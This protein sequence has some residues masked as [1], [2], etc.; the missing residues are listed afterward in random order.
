V[1]AAYLFVSLDVS[2][3]LRIKNMYHVGRFFW[4]SGVLVLALLSILFLTYRKQG[5]LFIL[6]GIALT[7]LVI[8]PLGSNR[9]LLN[10]NFGMWLAL[11]LA[12][13][14]F[15]NSKG[16]RV[17]A[18]SLDP[19]SL[20]LFK[21]LVLSMV[22]LYAL[23]AN[24][25]ETYRDS[26]DRSAL[27]HPVHHRYFTGLFT[28]KERARSIDGLMDA[29]G[30]YVHPTDY[31]LGDEYVSMFNYLTDCPPYMYNPNPMYFSED[32]YRYL[33]AKARA[34][35]KRLPVIM[36]AKGR[37]GTL[38]PRDVAKGLKHPDPLYD[39]LYNQKRA[40]IENLKHEGLY[41]KVWEN[42]FFEI[43]RP[44]ASTHF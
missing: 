40:L 24:L 43:W 7:L 25:H 41:S 34:E 9:S 4:R 28:T 1:I 5:S 13:S 31:V 35:R 19:H 26:P 11:P 22:A 20:F 2:I 42:D 21:T 30:H 14:V 17:F 15:I 18:F 3:P 44:G 16:I 32:V 37:L 38:W 6:T 29:I 10:A 27:I 23:N 8:T 39:R 33:Y 36:A 12:L